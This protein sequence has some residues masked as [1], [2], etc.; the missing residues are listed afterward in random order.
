MSY[1]R[2]VRQ[3]V[4]Q[5]L[6]AIGRRGQMD[7]TQRRVDDIRRERS[8][9]ENHI[10]DQYV[11]GKITRK[12]LL[13]RG[14]VVGMSIPLLSF[15]AAACGGDE[16]ASTGTTGGTTAGGNVQPGGT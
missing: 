8:E 7:E 9:L 6:E 10:I 2:A 13:R 4:T 14:S 5:R 15:I 3:K 16:A 12:D 1:K 11:E